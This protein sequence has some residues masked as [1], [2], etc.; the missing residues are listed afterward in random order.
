MPARGDLYLATRH[1]AQ[2]TRPH[3]RILLRFRDTNG[4]GLGFGENALS[5][6]G[7]RRRRARAWR[8]AGHRGRC[9]RDTS[10][11]I[12]LPAASEPVAER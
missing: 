1:R 10:V 5:V 6:S 7:G 4:Y 9:Q 11:L 3:L 2:P 12:Q 8:L